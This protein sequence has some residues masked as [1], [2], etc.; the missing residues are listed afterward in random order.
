[1]IKRNKWGWAVQVSRLQYMNVGSEHDAACVTATL[2]LSRW[3]SQSRQLCSPDFD[4]RRPFPTIPGSP[5]A[6]SY[7]FEEPG[8]VAVFLSKAYNRV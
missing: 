3:R 8:I 6:R 4:Q 1:M 5:C 7:L 2:I